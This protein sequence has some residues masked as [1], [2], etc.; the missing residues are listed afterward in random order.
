MMNRDIIHIIRHVCLCMVAIAAMAACS[1][2]TIIHEQEFPPEAVI[3][4]RAIS[5]DMKQGNRTRSI[6]EMNR[7]NHYEFGVFSTQDAPYGAD[8]ARLV[9][10]NYLV[11]YGP[12]ACFMPWYS[13]VLQTDSLQA[14]SLYT[15]TS[16]IY[17]TLGNA[18]PMGPTSG[19]STPM[20]KSVQQ[21]QIPKY[22]D[23]KADDYFFYAYAPYMPQG[24]A[25]QEGTIAI[26]HDDQGE[27]LHFNGLKAFYTDP[28]VQTGITAGRQT[29]DGYKATESVTA[30]NTELL[31]ANEA[32]YAANSFR[33]EAYLGDVALIFKHVNAKIRIAFWEDIY[34]YSVEL[35]DLVPQDVSITYGT[36]QAPYAGIALTPA[37]EAMTHY[38]DPQTPRA[39]LA[40]YYAQAQVRLQGIAPKSEDTRTNFTNIAVGNAATDTVC[41]QN[42]RFVTPKGT[43]AQTR[44]QAL[45]SPT[46]YYP[47]P[48]YESLLATPAHITDVRDGQQVAAST[49]YTLHVSFRLHPEDDAD[50]MD[51]YD[52]RVFIPADKCQWEAGNQYTYIFRLTSSVNG[53]SNPNKPDPTDPTTPWVDPHDPRI[54]DSKALNSI[55]LDGILVEDYKDE[56]VSPEFEF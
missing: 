28:V 3:P 53:T 34:G 8:D 19:V 42:L 30:S 38:P 50:D 47:L 2:D 48:N 56:I 22:W 29:M 23:S 36:G 24:E 4:N 5:F 55:V 7:A 35:Q 1:T 15:H 31:N 17:T 32:L 16:W 46:I 11:G 27:Y 52:A 12:T 37:T 10:R 43:L 20:T 13:V 9:M 14:D 21:Q 25:A 6:T 18:D 45:Y 39:E 40:P 26:G 33:S 41:R 51:I 49:G 54:P 44:D